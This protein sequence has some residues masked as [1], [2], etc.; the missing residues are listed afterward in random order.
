MNN[1][2][3]SELQEQPAVLQELDEELLE[4]VAGAG[5]FGCC[6]P[7]PSEPDHQAKVHDVSPHLLR[8]PSGKFVTVTTHPMPQILDLAREMTNGVT[9]ARLT[10]HEDGTISVV[11]GHNNNNNNNG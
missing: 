8:T 10:H 7:S 5:I 4:A 1:Q 11:G 9:D 3:K 6:N 2:E